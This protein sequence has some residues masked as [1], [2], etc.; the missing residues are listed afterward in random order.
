VVDVVDHEDRNRRIQSYT[1]WWC[2]RRE[3]AIES[4]LYQK[5]KKNR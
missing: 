5:K 1:P 3:E 4:L 2:W